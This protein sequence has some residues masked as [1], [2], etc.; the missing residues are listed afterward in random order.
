MSKKS[1]SVC[2]AQLS[3]WEG[4]RCVAH[5][6][7][8]R[9]FQAL[10]NADIVVAAL[11]QQNDPL[12]LYDIT[13]V[14]ERDYARSLYRPSLQVCLS[15]DWRFCWAG[16][17]LYGLY[18]HRLVPGPRNLRGIGSLFLYASGPEP[19]T[20]AALT[21]AM[22]WCNYQFADFSLLTALRGSGSVVA[23]LRGWDSTDA[24]AWTLV[25]QTDK[26]LR[27]YVRA[28]RFAPNEHALDSVVDR[29]RDFIAEA[30]VERQR[31]LGDEVA[32]ADPVTEVIDL[33]RI[34]APS[35]ALTRENYDATLNAARADGRPWRDGSN[36]P[37]AHMLRR[38]GAIWRTSEERDVLVARARVVIFGG[39]QDSDD[40]GVARNGD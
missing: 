17:G 25:G 16:K 4:S 11:E 23:R 37:I 32:T 36:K 20:L 18:R 26:E 7:T 8:K 34:Y 33:T 15:S 9:D 39:E 22:R 24:R 21:F 30:D 38:G 28:Q 19:V 10:S 27:A 6:L 35:S 13:R 5:G 29:C 3:A 14:V 31:R 12:S 1:C 40:R 2:K